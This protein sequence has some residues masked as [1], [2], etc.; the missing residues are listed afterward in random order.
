[1]H[2]FIDAN[3]YLSFYEQTQDELVEL[4]KLAVV[5]KNGKDKLWL[6]D[7]VKR[8]FWKNRE[9]SIASALSSFEKPSVL[10]AAPRLVC[11]DA[12]FK[13]LK[14]LAKATEKKKAEIIARVKHDV[15]S[16]K[17][18]ADNEVRNL[19]ALATEID[20]TGEIF[21]DAHERALRHSPPGKQDGVGDRLSWVA[22]LKM[23]PAKADLHIISMDGDFAGEGSSN[24]IKPYLQA[25]W[26][27]KNQG[28]IKLWKRTSQFLAAHFPEAVNAI[29]IERALMIERLE[30]SSN[31]AATHAVIAEFTDISHLSKPLADRLA[32]A[33]LTNS[34]VSWL[35]G[36]DD[37]KEFT[38]TFV[39]RYGAIISP[40]TKALLEKALDVA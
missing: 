3:I 16:E 26:T 6:P 31:F 32:N 4:A 27:K 21:A 39:T 14:E 17:T 34:Q 19:F 30:K 35:M 37:V 23:L 20:T 12:E 13:E 10:P 40:E 25:E 24:E 5:L 2:I 29:E 33:I 1:M 8:E 36:D 7:Q 38:K 11:E 22:L 28:S 9:G 18:V 15:A